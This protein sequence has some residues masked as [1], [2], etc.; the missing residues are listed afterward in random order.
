MAPEIL[1]EGEAALTLVGVTTRIGRALVEDLRRHDIERS[2]GELELPLMVLHA[3]DDVVVPVE[4]GERLFAAA[5]QPKSF[6]AIEGADHLLLRPL[7][8]ADRVGEAL[9]LWV[10]QF[11][12]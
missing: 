10:R 7:Q 11:S 5:R 9:G 4:H 12:E 3:P 2:A 6:V 1:T 8:A